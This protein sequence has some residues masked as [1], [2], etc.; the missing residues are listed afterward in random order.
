M[1]RYFGKR[2]KPFILA[3]LQ[4]KEF[5]FENFAQMVKKIVV[6]KFKANL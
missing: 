4:N 2:L 5:E 3:K 6:T 1:L